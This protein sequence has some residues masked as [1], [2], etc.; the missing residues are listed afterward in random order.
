VGS[1]SSKRFVVNKK[2]KMKPKRAELYNVLDSIFEIPL[3][4]YNGETGQ[5]LFKDLNTV[6]SLQV[7][8]PDHEIVRK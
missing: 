7:Y 8:Q 1:H 5:Y 6:Y 2:M 3:L 4:K